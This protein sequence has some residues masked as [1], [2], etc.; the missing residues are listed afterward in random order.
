MR[1]V[2]SVRT[3]EAATFAACVA[4][5]LELPLEA[6]PESPP[7]EDVGGWRT[8]RWLGGLGLGLVPILDAASFSWPGPWIGLGR[9]ASVD[10]VRIAWPSGRVDTVGALQGNQ[11]V[12]IKEGTG[13]IQST[14]LTHA[15]SADSQAGRR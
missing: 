8:S 12:T 5:I 13:I 6:V 14:P 3:S 9:A 10:A 1:E 4:S 7:G 2:A 11:M 15:A